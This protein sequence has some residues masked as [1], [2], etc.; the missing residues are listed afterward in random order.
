MLICG[1]HVRFPSVCRV[2]MLLAGS[3]LMLLFS[4][5]PSVAAQE[6]PTSSREF[7]RVAAQAGQARDANDMES[8]LALYHQALGM[9][10]GWAEGWWSLGT[11]LYDRDKYVEAARAFAKV[12]SLQ[13]QHGSAR[14]MLGL[15]EFE[16]GKDASALHDIQ[17]GKQRGVLE[18][19]QLRHVM[20]Y[21]EGVLLLRKGSFEAAQQA[22]DSL[23]QEGGEDSDLIL[24]LGM[25]VLR[26]RPDGLPPEG[27]TAR[28]IVFRAGKAESLAASKNFDAARREYY[29]LATDYTD[30]ANIHYA[31]G[32]FLL[33]M[34]E[35]DPAVVEFQHEIHNNPQHVLAR[36]EIAAVRYR[37]DSADGIKNAEEAVKLDPQRPFGHYL[38]GLLYLDTH[39]FAGA[40]SELEI[41]KRCRPN[42]PEIYFALGNAYARAG[43]KQEAARARAIFMRL[44]AKIKKETSDT[45]YGGQPSGLT[46]EQFGSGTTPKVPE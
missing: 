21:H 34:R 14:V 29:A 26:I 31:Y 46:R 28:E 9:R 15:C 2:A 41:A 32:R 7:N 36:L 42:L 37:V 40:I 10:P 30:A 13:P 35:I 38:L 20:L 22:L 5:L 17:S 12:V 24:A 43:R 18:D 19:A 23:S 4:F 39:N 45:V 11:I 3:F 6:K 8:A 1:V 44:N 25:S 27:S 16:L 33:E